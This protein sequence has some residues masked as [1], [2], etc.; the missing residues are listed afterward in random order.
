MVF[1]YET[2]KIDAN[3]KPLKLKHGLLI[4]FDI[5]NFTMQ[6]FS[7]WEEK[8]W[9]PGELHKAVSILPSFY[10]ASIPTFT[11]HKSLL[12]LYSMENP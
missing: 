5:Y 10:D 3:R 6:H 1:N 9:I 8:D 12:H 4:Q 11:C 7:V 2:S